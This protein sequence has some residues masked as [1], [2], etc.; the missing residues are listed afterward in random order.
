MNRGIIERNECKD[1]GGVSVRQAFVVGDV[2][3]M[4]DH[5][6][7]LLKHW[8]P[9]EQQLIFVGDYIDRGPNSKAVLERVR[10]LQAS[11]R[12]IC[13]RGNHEEMLRETLIAPDIY[14]ARYAS[15]GGTTTMSELLG[16][17]VEG[18]EPMTVV[19]AL[20]EAHPWLEDW[21]NRLP[22][23]TQFG[24]FV[25]VH[26]GVNLTLN[27]WLQTSL[28]DFVWIRDPFYTE[29]NRTGRTFIFGHTPVMSLHGDLNQKSVWHFNG[30]YGI[31]GG[32]VYGG[33]LHGLVIDATEVIEN[34]I[35]GS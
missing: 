5:L 23:Y 7:R 33:V 22:F 2:H 35:V 21:L 16:Y 10:E 14:Y 32:A 8:R 29:I 31:D 4:I 18:M 19:N 34:Y 30:K 11:H 12:A 27:D 6:D 17:S 26:A 1:K 3:G 15:N 25:V 24:Q 13:L 28:R 9:E 20:K